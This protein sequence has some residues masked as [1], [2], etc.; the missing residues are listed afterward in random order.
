MNTLLHTFTLILIYCILSINI[1]RK[2][3]IQ[4][5]K[6]WILVFIISVLVSYLNLHI[7]I[8]TII[9][10]ITYAITIHM[11]IKTIDSNFILILSNTFFLCGLRYS[12]HGFYIFTQQ[13]SHYESII[14]SVVQ[15]LFLFSFYFSKKEI[16]KQ[17]KKEIILFSLIEVLIASMTFILIAS[18]DES[19]ITFYWIV[20]S[21]I[22][23][24]M[25]SFCVLFYHI[26]KQAYLLK[27]MKERELLLKLSKDQYEIS[28]KQSSELSKHKH[29]TLHYLTVLHQFLESNEIETAK[30]HI[31]SLTNSLNYSPTLQHSTN[32]YMNSLLQ[33]KTQQYSDIQFNIKMHI[34]KEQCDEL[35]DFCI[36][37]SHLIDY[38]VKI[39]QDYHSKKEL[40]IHCFQKDNQILLE[41]AIDSYDRKYT[42]SL[43]TSLKELAQ[44]NQ[45]IIQEI[46]DQKYRI[47]LSFIVK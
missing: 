45:G 2:K 39:I 10:T 17:S 18:I 37:V 5:Y 35:I 16:Y 9:I 26:Q 7:F 30:K 21:I 46:Q 8:E 12:V 41:T 40:T 4:I 3:S 31:E 19:T 24:I 14:A 33:Y 25:I 32:V 27:E 13:S 38:C 43:P 1:E 47:Q 29:D 11:I 44:K 28:L 22:S 6:S 15:L 42:D 20:S 36:L 34:Q 23:F